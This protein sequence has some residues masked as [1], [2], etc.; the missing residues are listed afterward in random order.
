MILDHTLGIFT[1]PDAEW[2]KIRDEKRSKFTEFLMHIPWLALVPCV[3]AYI[4]LSQIGF[5]NSAG[6]T[7]TLTEQS[8]LTLVVITYCAIQVGAF[9][10]GEIIN[11]MTTT[12]S[13]A[14]VPEHHGMAMAVYVLTPLYFSGLGFLS[15]NV[16]VIGLCT[17]AGMAYGA[18]LLF[19]GMPILMDIDKDRAFMFSCSVLTAGLVILVSTRIGSVIV[20]SMGFGPQLVTT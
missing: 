1:N 4:G 18:Y 9:A 11:W 16:Y 15:G 10:F 17:I 7:V 2:A 5:A 14:Q 13:D 3:S 19:E 12:F 8:A 20:W 6:A